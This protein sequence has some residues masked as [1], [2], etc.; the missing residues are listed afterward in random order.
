MGRQEDEGADEED[1]E[2]KEKEEVVEEAGVEETREGRQR[3]GGGNF[4]GLG[5]RGRE[6]CVCNSAWL[7]S[8]MSDGGHAV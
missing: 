7:P 6:T 3:Q 5:R 2:K 1:E 4:L 8:R